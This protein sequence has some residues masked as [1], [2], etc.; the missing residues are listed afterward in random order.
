MHPSSKVVNSDSLV[1]TCLLKSDIS[2]KLI[3]IESWFF[4]T[5]YS[6]HT[7]RQTVSSVYVELKGQVWYF[8]K[9]LLSFH[10]SEEVKHKF[11]GLK[12]KYGTKPGDMLLI[13]IFSSTFKKIE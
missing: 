8:V 3:Y 9:K 4:L 12:I 1:L 2:T 6:K 7:P 13:S 11:D 5:V 10:L